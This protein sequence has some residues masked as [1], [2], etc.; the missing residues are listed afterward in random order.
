MN[1]DRVSVI[2]VSRH[3]PDALIRCLTAVE[4][5]CFEPFEV[6]VVADPAGAQRLAQAGFGSVK[7][8]AF[9]EPNISAAR[10]AGLSA[11][12]GE[13]SV[14]IDDDAVPEPTWLRHLVVPFAE[15]LVAAAGGYVIGRNGISYQHRG[16]RVDGTGAHRPLQV[17]RPEGEV[18]NTAPGDAVKTEGTNC[19]FRTENL[20]AMGGFD[21]AFRFYLDETDV[22]L[23]LAAQSA[24][25]AIVPRAVVHHGFAAS[26][27]RRESRMPMTLHDV[28]AS[29]AVF[30]RK[31][32][33]GDPSPVLDAM[34]REQRA[35]LLRFMVR[36]DC[37]PADVGRLLA[38][39][40]A[41]FAEGR[42]RELRPL[43]PIVP[44]QSFKPF[45]PRRIFHGAENLAG[46]IWQT[47]S[48]RRD[49]AKMVAAGR[50]CSLY[51]F[52]PT[53]RYHTVRF[54]SRGYW[55]QQGGLFGRS[56]RSDPFIKWFGFAARVAREVARVTP[57]RNCEG[58]GINS[59]DLPY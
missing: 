34:R 9:D 18:F 29:Q 37:E 7:M 32:F 40:E 16:R 22:N 28:G 59:S 55:L 17:A 5:L 38:T 57:F 6:I 1:A 39:L 36:G 52:S 11:A 51:V 43:Q 53:A 13:I 3:R 19:A 45:R 31:H 35:R 49:A 42:E 30:L 48:R 50:R 21:P 33:S 58:T 8:V 46:R 2:V 23:R 12:G 4:Q 26:D 56:T 27:R 54:D 15:A 44:D 20:R 47:G 25:V 10:N 14:F 24:R 41:G